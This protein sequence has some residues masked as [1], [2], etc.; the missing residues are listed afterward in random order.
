MA[1]YQQNLY[2][3]VSK[4]KK[5]GQSVGLFASQAIIQQDLKRCRLRS[6]PFCTSAVFFA[7][8]IIYTWLFCYF[9]LNMYYAAIEKTFDFRYD[10]ICGNNTTCIVDFEIPTS[11]TGT[12]GL[13]YR[14]TNFKQMRREISSSFNAKMLQGKEISESDME[15]C[16]PRLY[17][18]DK[19]HLNNL[20]VP[21]G[22]L[23]YLVFNDTFSVIDQS[24]FSEE[25]E[26]IVLDVDR[27]EMF[28]APN[29]KYK[30]STNWLQDN[31][32][33]EGGQINP[34][35]IIWMRQ[36]AFHPFRK[37]YAISKTGIPKGHYRMSIRNNYP[38]SSFKGE[39]HFVI[40]EVGYFGTS[41]YGPAIVFG[42]MAIFFL[43]ASAILGIM[44]YNR[45]KPTSK[46]H[47]NQLKNIFYRENNK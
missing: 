43:I 21:C 19:N 26:D 35:F 44:G 22:I 13:Y 38:T 10:D 32:L 34:H 18:D 31:G 23:P 33:F 47:P 36:S 39:K 37:L 30:N 20:F 14:L 27:N 7:L 9:G 42:V 6:V 17:L 1:R 8:S 25:S 2:L 40:A 5:G 45:K 24:L 28:Q 4:M 46:F 15:K 11:I 41:A 16:Q 29:I 12:A 3:D